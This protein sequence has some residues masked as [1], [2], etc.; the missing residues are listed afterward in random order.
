[1]NPF[2]AICRFSELARTLGERR[3]KLHRVASAWCRDRAL[4]DDLVQETLTKALKNMGQLREA[5]ASDSW[6]FQIMSNCWRDHFRRERVLEEIGTFADDG[7]LAFEDDHDGNEIVARVRDAVSRLPVGQREVLALVD[8][9][10]FSYGEVSQL[11][12]IPLGTVTSRICRA[13][14]TLRNLLS[15]LARRGRNDQVHVLRR[16]K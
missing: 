5:Q 15:D 9:Q 12:E 2:H 14:E 6:L 10:G 4:A 16:V 1:M 13:R 8:L 3:K 11:L 7:A